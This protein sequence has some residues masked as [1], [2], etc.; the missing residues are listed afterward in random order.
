MSDIMELFKKISQ[1]SPTAG[2][3]EYIIC[4]LGNPGDKYA[5]TRHMFELERYIL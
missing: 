4:G 5:R 1:Q 2:P 3:P